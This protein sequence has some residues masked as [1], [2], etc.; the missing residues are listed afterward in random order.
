MDI[1]INGE[2]VEGERKI[3]NRVKKEVKKKAKKMESKYGKEKKSL[4][5]YKNKEKPKN[6]KKY[7]MDL[8]NPHFYLKLGL[9][10]L[11]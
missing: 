8:G 10:H 4:R 3:E 7:I 1:K 6:E 9:T 11:K 5:W 2:I